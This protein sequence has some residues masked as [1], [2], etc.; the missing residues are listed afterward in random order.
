MDAAEFAAAMQ[1]WAGSRPV[2]VIQN[3]SSVTALFGSD[4]AV[5]GDLRAA[6]G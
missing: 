1:A 6:A 2:A 4:P 3:G 5:L